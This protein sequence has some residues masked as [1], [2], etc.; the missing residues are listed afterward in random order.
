MLVSNQW[1][2]SALDVCFV[3]LRVWEPFMKVFEVDSFVVSGITGVVFEF[4]E[5]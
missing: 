5:I 4:R 3:Q 1:V 2:V